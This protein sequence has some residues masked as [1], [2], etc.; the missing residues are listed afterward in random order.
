MYNRSGLSLGSRKRALSFLFTNVMILTLQLFY[1]INPSSP[2]KPNF[3][4]K[5]DIIKPQPQYAEQICDHG[6]YTRGDLGCAYRESRPRT[7]SIPA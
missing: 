1:S 4:K 3:N 2:L 6:A 7:S 5:K